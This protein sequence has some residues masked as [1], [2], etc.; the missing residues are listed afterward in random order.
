MYFLG[1]LLEW[2]R[3][4]SNGRILNFHLVELSIFSLDKTII[5]MIALLVIQ[6]SYLIYKKRKQDNFTI[7]WFRELVKFVFVTYMILLVHL[8]V[9]RYDWMW[10]QDSFNWHRSFDELNWVPLVDTIKLTKGSTFS[11]WYNFFG[12]I[13]WFM[14]FGL[15]VPYIFRMKHAFFKTL[16]WGLMFS[17]SIETMQFYLETG[18]SHIDDVIFNGAGVILGYLM[19]DVLQ[20]GHMYFK[21][22]RNN[23][24]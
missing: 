11:Y 21:R 5:Y 12:N 14:P 22:R 24:G 16:F 15:V 10:W 18:V 19:Y 23:N 7:N 9:L 2:L 17:L 6:A 4:L 8:T 3:D 1:P 20:I 13:L